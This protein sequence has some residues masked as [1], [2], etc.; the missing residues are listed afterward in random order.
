MFIKFGNR[1]RFAELNGLKTA[2]VASFEQLLALPSNDGADIL[3]LR[4][5]QE[6]GW[7]LTEVKSL[8]A[9]PQRSVLTVTILEDPLEQFT[10][11]LHAS[12]LGMDLKG[13]VRLIGTNRKNP[14]VAEVR[15]KFL[16]V[17]G[18]QKQ[19]DSIIRSLGFREHHRLQVAKNLKQD[20]FQYVVGE[21][22]RQLDLILLSHR[23]DESL[24]LLSRS[25][26]C[27][28]ERDLMAALR[29]AKRDG[30]P[31]E[32]VGHREVELDLKSL[33]PDERGIVRS[34]LG[35]ADAQLYRHYLA[36]FEQRLAVDSELRAAAENVAE[37]KET[38]F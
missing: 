9:E 14:V 4:D 27:W 8:I 32:S 1:R 18:W 23:L 11:N 17:L 20:V 2:E 25:A 21:L 7:N 10:A 30:I 33:G 15:R 6:R 13:L 12:S 36:M 28:S 3:I 26:F 19:S 29:S 38:I 22:D 37:F 24:V 35:G 34:W 31:L 5:N 16:A